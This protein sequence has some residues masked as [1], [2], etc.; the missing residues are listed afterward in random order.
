MK[1]IL[2]LF[3]IIF[4][5]ARINPFEPVINYDNTIKVVKQEDFKKAKVYLPKDARVLKKV[6]FVYQSLND[7]IKQKEV[8][9]NKNIDF[10]SPIVI[11][12]S[13]QDFQIKEIRFDSL[14]TLFIKNKK[15]FI[16]T[17]DKLIRNMFLIKPFRLVLDFK[18][19]ADFL[20]IKRVIKNSV[21]T[22]VIVG[23]HNGYYRVVLYFDANYK[24]KLTK[25]DEGVK[26]EVY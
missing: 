25:M 3:S 22:K 24:Y 11:T 15:I 16:K 12:H 6:I 2:L 19:E 7:D 23:N 9:I 1:I 4:A 10:H 26:I 17:K 20:T 18:K 13:S 5:F 14:F 21:V 8:L